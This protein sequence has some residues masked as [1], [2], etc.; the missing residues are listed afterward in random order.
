MWLN[1]PKKAVYIEVKMHSPKRTAAYT[2]Y[3][4]NAHSHERARTAKQTVVQPPDALE[5]VR[6]K[7]K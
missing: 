1:R 4:I 3:M 7:N 2:S 6:I 5:I